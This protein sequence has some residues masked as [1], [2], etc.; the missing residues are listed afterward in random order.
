M[1]RRDIREVSA[2]GVDAIKSGHGEVVEVRIIDNAYSAAFRKFCG[3][4]AL[5]KTL[6]DTPE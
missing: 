1:R 5:E 3:N 2:H 4:C 6:L